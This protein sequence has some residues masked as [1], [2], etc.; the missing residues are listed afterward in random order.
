MSCLLSIC[1]QISQTLFALKEKVNI[2]L[3][4]FQEKKN[5]VCTSPWFIVRFTLPRTKNIREETFQRFG[6]LFHGNARIV[7]FHCNVRIKVT[8]QGLSMSVYVIANKL[9]SLPII[10]AVFVHKTPKNFGTVVDLKNNL[11]VKFTSIG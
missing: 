8:K 4:S 1:T 10:L 5:L 6:V 2:F 3:Y 9:W 7:L 11:N